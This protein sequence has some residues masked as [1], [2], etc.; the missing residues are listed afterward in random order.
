MKQDRPRRSSRMRLPFMLV[1]GLCVLSVCISGCGTQGT[2]TATSHAIASTQ[3]TAPCVSADP[4]H[5]APSPAPT[6][7]TTLEQAYWCLLDHYVTGKA[8][9][10]RVLLNS[11]FSAL[12]QELLRKGLDRPTAM[13]PALLGDR[14]ADWNAFSAVYQRVSNALPHNA[15]LQQDLVAATMRGMVQSL[16]DNHTT[17]SIPPPAE[18]LKQFPN[19]A[20]Y[21]LGI[22]TSASSGPS[23]LPEARPPLFVTEVQPGSPAE[24]QQVA[25]GDIITA[26]NGSAPFTNNQLN[27]GVMAWL[28]PQLSNNA[29]VQVTLMRPRTG[30]T[31]TVALTPTLFAPTMAP[32]VSARVLSNSLAYVKLT[33]FTPDAGDQVLKAINSLHVGDHLRGIILDLRDNHGGSPDG[34]S[35]LLGA[36]VHGKIVGYLVDGEGKRTALST[37]DTVSLL[38]QPLV[39]LTNRGCASAC[40][41]FSGAVKDLGIAPLVGTRTAGAIA[42]TASDYFLNDGS[43]LGITMQFGLGARGEKLDGTGVAPD[44][45][46]PLTAQDLSAGHDPDIEKAMSLLR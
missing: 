15:D 41:E 33:Q 32:V 4:T 37:T 30:K 46:L 27:P 28:Y 29:V 45:L 34:V 5:P 26:V 10:D 17:W 23:F 35:Q 43:M 39:V 12:V 25:L 40:E 36:F 21:G 8:L 2:G 9:D 38:H 7:L 16:H 18:V 44:Y 13:P 11:A 1:L 6:A 22:T 24:R 14:Q 3:S 42:G 20:F 19:G 31:W